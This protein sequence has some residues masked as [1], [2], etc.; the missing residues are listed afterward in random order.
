MSFSII[1]SHQGEEAA[2]AIFA[3]GMKLVQNGAHQAQVA[4][5][6]LPSEHRPCGLTADFPDHWEDRP[7]ALMGASFIGTPHQNDDASPGRPGQ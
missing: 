4:G 7:C 2:Q 5:L 3:H 6:A 1:P